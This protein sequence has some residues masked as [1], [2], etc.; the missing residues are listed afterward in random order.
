MREVGLALEGFQFPCQKYLTRTGKENKYGNA[1]TPMR[2][3]MCGKW[4]IPLRA[5][6][7]LIW[8]VRQIFL[9]SP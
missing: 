4:R 5:K 7:D 8:G 2:L 9:K 3:A 1:G 6:S